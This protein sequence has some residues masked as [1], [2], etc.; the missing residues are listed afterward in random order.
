MP[1]LI[2]LF[3]ARAFA[4]DSGCSYLTSNVSTL[5]QCQVAAGNSG[6]PYAEF[7]NGNCYGCQ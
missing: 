7:E 4:A 5:L 6:F 2:L 1:F 3:T